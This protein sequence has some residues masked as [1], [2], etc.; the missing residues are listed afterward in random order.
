MSTFVRYGIK[1]QRRSTTAVERAIEQL[2]LL[3][4]AVVDGG[5]TPDEI[6]KFSAAFD[7]ARTEMQKQF[8]GREALEA[9][10]EHNTV[11]VPMLYDKLFLDL[12]T[13]PIILD[14][15]R[16]MVGDYVILNQQNGIVN[17]GNSAR[18]NQGAYHRDLP[19]QHFVS[20]RPLA[21]N[22][23]FC[24]DPFTAENGAT[25]VVPGSHKEEL[26]PSDEVVEA[27]QVQ[28]PAPAGSF[29]VL[30][31]MVFHSGG[32]NRTGRERRGVNHVYTIPLIKPQIDLPSVLGLDYTA[33]PKV[34][35]LLGYD[36]QVPTDLAQY[37][38]SRNKKVG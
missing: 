3:G 29:I 13:N 1:E 27:L 36:V 25:F 28:A 14:I 17:P 37:Y 15:C 23:L 34:R 21:I 2:K 9:I 8:G 5:Y 16:R 12:A 26:F 4:Y 18:Y 20:S 19:Y 7:G 10:D 33:D 6:A 31:C 30:D 38:R 35:Q 32:I 24:L 22:A 11:R